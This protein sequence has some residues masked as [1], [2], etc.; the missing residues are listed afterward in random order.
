MREERI[1][2][3]FRS[4]WS[5]RSLETV[6]LFTRQ[7]RRPP[8]QSDTQSPGG[9]MDARRRHLAEIEARRR[10]KRPTSHSHHSRAR[11]ASARTW[12]R[13]ITNPTCTAAMSVNWTNRR[14][15]SPLWSARNEARQSRD[16]AGA[17][18]TC[19]VYRAIGYVS[20]PISTRGRSR[21]R[22][23]HLKSSAP[24][25]LCHLVARHFSAGFACHR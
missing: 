8:S 25:G 21:Q 15:R 2:C 9:S 12:R 10:R 19:R 3:R 6:R 24:E 7:P 23:Y 5:R 20:G 4:R 16:V 14:R 1:Y 11:S 17:H 13:W 22:L 18:R